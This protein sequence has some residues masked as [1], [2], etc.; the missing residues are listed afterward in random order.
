MDTNTP[1]SRYTNP[2]G[3]SVEDAVDGIL[4]VTPPVDEHLDDI[5]VLGLD[6]DILTDGDDVL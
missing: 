3:E 5:D 2:F 6:T 4:G 1:L